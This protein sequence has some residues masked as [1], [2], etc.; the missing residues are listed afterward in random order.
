M[1][2]RAYVDDLALWKR[3]PTVEVAA[4]VARALAPTRRFEAA[5]DWQRSSSKIRQWAIAPVLH[6]WL[7]AAG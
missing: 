3:G 7:A 4:E 1:R 5:V 6:K 2:R